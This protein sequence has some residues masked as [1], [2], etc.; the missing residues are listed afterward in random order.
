MF[1]VYIYYTVLT[2]PCSLVITCWKGLTSYLS[3]LCVMFPRVF[4]H[5]PIWFLL[6][7]RDRGDWLALLSPYPICVKS[8]LN[9]H[10]HLLCTSNEGF[11]EHAHM[12]R[13]V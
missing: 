2:V 12:R 8:F 7:K 11:G 10:A 4:C 3:Y 13:V 5:F 9:I 1:Q 6:R